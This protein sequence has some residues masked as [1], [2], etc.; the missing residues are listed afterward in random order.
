MISVRQGARLWLRS[1]RRC[2]STDGESTLSKRSHPSGLTFWGGGTGK[3]LELSASRPPLYKEPTKHNVFVNR[4]YYLLK[5]MG[6]FSPKA[7]LGLQSEALFRSIEEQATLNTWFDTLRL[8]RTWITEHSLIALHVWLF[9]NRFKVDYNASGEYCGRRMQELL[10]E[11][12]WEDTTMRIRNAGIAEISVNKQLGMVQSAT[13]DDMFAYDAAIKEV[14]DGD[15]MELAGA[16]WKGVFREDEASDTAAVMLLTD[17]VRQEV[18]NVMLHPKEDLYRGWIAWGP[19][20]GETREQRLAR[21]R[22]MLAGEWR[23]ALAPD[24]RL[25]FY[26]TTTHE[27]RWDAPPEGL[28]SRRRVALAKHLTEAAEDQQG[29]VVEKSDSAGAKLLD[30]DAKAT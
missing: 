26:H 28:T 16:L 20:A 11:R 21:Q 9:H 7:R 1:G 10:F 24:G 3:G 5:G 14:T 23:D 17:Y 18:M 27:R 30:A 22:S 19:A 6:V 29:A 25:F 2:L 4:Y 12:F 8:P 15:S 13:F